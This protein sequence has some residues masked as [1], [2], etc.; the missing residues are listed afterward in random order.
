MTSL[1]H[2]AIRA[3]L[4]AVR[5][6]CSCGECDGDAGLLL[7]AHEADYIAPTVAALM[8]DY[9]ARAVVAVPPAADVGDEAIRALL[10]E[11]VERIPM[12][13]RL[14]PDTWD[15]YDGDP[16]PAV[17]ELFDAQ[18]AEVEA[19]RAE[20]ERLTAAE[21]TW[22]GQMR[23]A[24]DRGYLA[25]EADRDAYAAERVRAALLDAAKTIEACCSDDPGYKVGCRDA[26]GY[27]R[28]RAGA[29]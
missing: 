17:K 16:L 8:E 23:D 22:V 24:Y 27:L 2:D 5:V 19:L 20:V 9:A 3:A 26:A 28:N 29:S 7:M 11:H 12:A 15:Q 13:A 25:A 14:Y 10:I 21:T 18:A 1:D 6:P 4:R